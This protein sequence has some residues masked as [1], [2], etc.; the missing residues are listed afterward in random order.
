MMKGRKVQSYR[1]NLVSPTIA[2]QAVMFHYVYSLHSHMDDI[3]SM[4][5]LNR[6]FIR[7]LQKMMTQTE[8]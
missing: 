5:F 1:E 6:Q 3:G 2:P 7:C 4:N 8:V